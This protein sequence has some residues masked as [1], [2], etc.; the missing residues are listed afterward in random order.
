MNILIA[1]AHKRN[2]SIG[3]E[4]EKKF[5]KLNHAYVETPDDLLNFDFSDFCPSRLSCG[6]VRPAMSFITWVTAG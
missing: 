1:S 4:L 3:E 6:Q 2:L 5:S